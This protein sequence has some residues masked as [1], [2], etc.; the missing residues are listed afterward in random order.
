MKFRFQYISLLSATLLLLAA[1]GKKN[2]STQPVRKNITET[3][4][5]SGI[6]EPDD[7]YQLTAQT[8]GYLSQLLLTE[9]QYIQ[10]GMVVAYIDNPQNA[11]NDDGAK[12]LLSI[13]QY[14]ASVAA[15]AFKQIEASIQ[16]AEAKMLQDKTQMDR[17]EVLYKNGSATK[18]EYENTV[19]AY[20]TSSANAE[21]LRQNYKV[22]KKQAEQQL[23]AQ[24]TQTKVSN[25]ISNYNQLKAIVGGKVYKKLK[26]R[27]DYV[28]KGDVLATIGNPDYL[29]AKLSVDESSIS[30]VKVGQ[31]VLLQLNTDKN[32]TYKG[33]IYE[34][35]PS[36]DESTQSFFCKAKF[37]DSL[38]FRISGTQL[39]ANIIIA[40]KENALLIPRSYLGY[41]NKVMVKD[42][43]EPIIVK[44]GFISEEWVEIISGID[45]KTIIT[46]DLN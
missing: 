27:G 44:T 33:I 29:Y 39:Q 22:L 12:D 17:Y 6:L 1:C 36:F 4:F 3:V 9:G 14:N 38:D 35:L 37:S 13:A 10:P 7:M 30:K 5:A 45:E 8:D 20:N 34:I 42:Q 15:P 32:K 26:E 11:L 18:V 23:I 40:E 19:L 2:T 46:E 41:G 16:A 43:K 31:T 24:Q 28:K 21:A 25:A